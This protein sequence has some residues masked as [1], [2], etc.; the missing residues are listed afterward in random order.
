MSCYIFKIQKK[1]YTTTFIYC[2]HINELFVVPPNDRRVDS[3]NL[4]TPYHS[5]SYDPTVNRY[6]STTTNTTTM[7]E[8]CTIVEGQELYLHFLHEQVRN[9]GLSNFD[10]SLEDDLK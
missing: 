7:P 5:D 4:E 3:L 1:N 10:S 8:A 6:Q 2:T 9:A